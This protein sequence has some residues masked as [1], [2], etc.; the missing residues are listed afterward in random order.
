MHIRFL[1]VGDRQPSWVDDAFDI[2]I[3]R[4]PREW[5]FQ[6]EVIP[7]K[8]AQKTINLVMHKMQKVK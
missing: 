4:Y 3:S 1:T 2:Y 8:N 6:L 7:T 5:K